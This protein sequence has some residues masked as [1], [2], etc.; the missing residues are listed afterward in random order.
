MT[1]VTSLLKYLPKVSI[2]IVAILGTLTT[3]EAAKKKH[4]PMTIVYSFDEVFTHLEKNKEDTLFC[5]NVDSVIQHKYLGSPGW[6][7]NR[8]SKLSKRFGDFFKAKKRVAEEQ[9]LID[10]V[11]SKECLELNVAERFAQILAECSYSLLGISSLGIESVSSTLK[12]LKE[13]GIELHSR[14]FPTEDF[15][16]ETT[17][18][19]STSAL[20]QEGV[21]F[22]ST[23][24]FSEAM[25]L[26]FIYENKMPKNIVFLTDDPEEIKTLGREC[27]DLGIKFFGLVYYPAA[28][29]IFSY[30]YP[31]SAAVEIQ[32]E[33]A[34]AVISDAT[35]QLSLDSLNQKS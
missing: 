2:L 33:H 28:E 9:V 12:S 26:L 32:E 8:L 34:L 18:R 16:L 35:A 3:A 27:I 10:T 15:F 25:K 4:V 17:Q 7:Q 20:V 6:Y 5:I 21:L 24:G 14:A 11:I 13:C 19:C 1:N 30:V 22:C 23:L 31:Y 29:S